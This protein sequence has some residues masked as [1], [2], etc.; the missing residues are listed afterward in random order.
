MAEIRLPEENEFVLATVKKIMP[1]GAFCVLTEYGN[2]EAFLHV[3]EVASRWIKNIHEFLSENEKLVVKILRVD[4]EKGQIDVSLRRVSEQEK[5][6]KLEAVKRSSRSDKLLQLALSK[7]KS[8]MKLPELTLKLEEIYGEAYAALEEALEKDD[9]LA[10][11]PIPD[12][13]KKKI[14]EI[15]RKSI[16][17]AKVSVVA[18]ITL[19]CFGPEGIEHIKKVLAL[20]E[21]DVAIHYLGAPRYKLE[22]FS[23]DYKDANKKA[24]KILGKMR[25][26]LGKDCAFE[27][28]M[29]E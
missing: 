9:A 1:Y 17:K 7:S 22:V 16:K 6:N 23:T 12:A 4:R 15:V 20:N 10:E 21:P 3:S 14:I 29:E 5:R 28:K 18:D 8:P 24:E 11:V 19:R 13:L 27:Y 26:G 2:L 25:L